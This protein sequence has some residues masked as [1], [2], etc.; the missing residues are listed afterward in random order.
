LVTDSAA[1]SSTAACILG[2]NSPTGA[3]LAI[4]RPGA[5]FAKNTLDS[6]SKYVNSRRNIMPAGEKF[7]STKQKQQAE[8]I[9]ETYEARGYSEEESERRS[10]A[11]VNKLHG[12][13]EVRQ[14]DSA[15]S[16][17]RNRDKDKFG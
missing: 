15:S 10:W 6:F 7:K 5:E 13:G 1:L 14:E 16:A 2:N 11:I 17:S 8:H 12:G 3:R 4:L 9:E